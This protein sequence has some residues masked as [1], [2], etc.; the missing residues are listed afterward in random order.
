M[1]GG[2]LLREV[3]RNKPLRACEVVGHLSETA[4][5]NKGHDGVDAEGATARCGMEEGATNN[6]SELDAVIRSERGE[7]QTRACWRLLLVGACRSSSGAI[8][9]LAAEGMLE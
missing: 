4:G 5:R 6:Q 7:L 2:N 3:F 1:S 9:D 8:I